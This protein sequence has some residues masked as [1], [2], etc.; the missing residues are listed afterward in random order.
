MV[1]KSLKALACLLINNKKTL[2]KGW[3]PSTLRQLTNVFSS[4]RHIILRTII[5]KEGRQQ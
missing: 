2:F 5:T 3:D 1:G 4:P